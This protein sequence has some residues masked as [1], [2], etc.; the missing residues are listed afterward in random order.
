MNTPDPASVS[1]ASA[2]AA[3]ATPQVPVGR[4]RGHKR[5]LARMALG[6][7]GVVFG[8]IGTSP[9]Y[10]IQQTFGSHG[11]AVDSTN[12]FGVLSLM[13]WSLI[14]VVSVKYGYN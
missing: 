3:V 4:L 6:A 2:T 9:L 14:M 12:V 13:I 11:L 8:D 7:A 1:D 5:S 10:A